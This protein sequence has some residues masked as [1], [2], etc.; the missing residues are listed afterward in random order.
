[1]LDYGTV[2]SI[3]EARLSA[4]RGRLRDE[5][6]EHC[7]LELELSVTDEDADSAWSELNVCSQ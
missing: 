5:G 2:D 3:F 7:V 1:M 6:A 4:R